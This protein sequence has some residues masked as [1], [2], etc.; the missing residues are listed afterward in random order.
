MKSKLSTYLMIFSALCAG[1]V[2][3][4][5]LSGC[6]PNKPVTRG[7][8]PTNVTGPGA[9]K[10]SERTPSQPKI[11]PTSEPFSKPATET[12]DNPTTDPVKPEPKTKVKVEPEQSAA[13]PRGPVDMSNWE[14]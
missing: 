2:F 6:Q 8:R 1:A 11:E 13:V 9:P 10:R 14:P 5:L 4:T 3:S 7:S 12:V